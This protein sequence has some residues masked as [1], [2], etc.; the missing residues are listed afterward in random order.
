MLIVIGSANADK[1]ENL[2]MIADALGKEN[3]IV[4]YNNNYSIVIMKNMVE[5]D[6][7]KEE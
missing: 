4:A 6:G 2:D 1:K 7:N 5:E 3:F